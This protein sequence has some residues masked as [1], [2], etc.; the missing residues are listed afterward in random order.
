ME[1]NEKL[2]KL[3]KLRR[4]EQINKLKN[5][6]EERVAAMGQESEKKGTKW[7]QE[8]IKEKEN[9]EKKIEEESLYNLSNIKKDKRKYFAFLVMLVYKFLKTEDIPNRYII[10]VGG[11]QKGI[12]VTIRNTDLYKAFT[13]SFIEKFDLFACKA[14]AVEVGNTIAHLEGFR[15]KSEGGGV[16][17]PDQIDLKNYG[18]IRRSNIK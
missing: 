1:I 7:V 2:K 9:R 15:H 14:T 4:T 16:L 13:P 8:D 3:S 17:L 18:N 11:T 5:E 12:I 6:Y 10:E